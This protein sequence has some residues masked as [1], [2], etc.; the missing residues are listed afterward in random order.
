MKPSRNQ[1]SLNLFA[2]ADFDGLSAS[3]DRADP[4]SIKS[5]TGILLIFGTVP[6]LWSSNLKTEIALS[7]LEAEYVS[8]SQVMRELVL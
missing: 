7:T 8:L 2:D 4:I 6:I 3:K 1:L 5:C